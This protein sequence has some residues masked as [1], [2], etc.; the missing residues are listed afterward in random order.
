MIWIV[1]VLKAEKIIEKKLVFD[2]RRYAKSQSQMQ[3]GMFVYE[4]VRSWMTGAEQ[5]TG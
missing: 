5:V 3:V 2:F 1:D 4:Q